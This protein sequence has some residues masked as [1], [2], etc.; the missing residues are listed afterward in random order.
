MDFYVTFARLS[1]ATLPKDRTLDGRDILPLLSGEPGAKSPHD[2]VYFYNG[3]Q[4]Q[5]VR[6]GPW[7]LYL[8]LPGRLVNAAGKREPFAGELYDL[9]EDLGETRNVLPDHPD[10]VARLITLAERARADLG[11][12][13]LDGAGQRPAGMVPIPSAR[14]RN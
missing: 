12:D 6:S 5:A 8:P 4:L 3:A 2:A 13:G 14:V 7:K 10:V 11:D 9:V 1:G